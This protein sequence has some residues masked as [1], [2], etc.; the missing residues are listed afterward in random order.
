[1]N[2]EKKER[3]KKKITGKKL[4]LLQSMLFT[5]IPKTFSRCLFV[6]IC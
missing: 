1:M 2:G 5:F 4:A 6:T 3:K